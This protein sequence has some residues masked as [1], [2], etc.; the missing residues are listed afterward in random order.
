[1]A[2]IVLT[3][4]RILVGTT[5]ISSFTGSFSPTS[6]VAM[7]TAT[8]FGSGGF[9]QKLPGLKSFTE[10]FSGYA[11]YAA[12][13]VAA[14]FNSSQLGQQ[15]LVTKAPTGGATAGDQASFGRFLIDN[16]N[17]PGGAVGDV[18]TF[19]MSMTSDTASLEGQIAAPLA[20]RSSTLTGSVLTMTGPTAS[21]RVYIG[22]NLTAATSTATM[23][24]TLQSATL[25]GFGSPTTRIT[26]PATVAA[27][28]GWQFVSLAGP[29][30]D[31]FWRAVL[32]YS[33]SG[34]L[35]SQVV[36]GVA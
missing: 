6:T 25:V 27:T 21:Q 5:D 31:G 35:T 29:V 2:A 19:D 20:L 14:V 18:A 16:V 17:A 32:T 24:V 13:E 12:G 23:V 3:D 34:N 10:S 1:M 33:G 30:T 36:V 11:A 8:T 9:E 4:T 28:P 22:L 15:H 26:L 7:Q